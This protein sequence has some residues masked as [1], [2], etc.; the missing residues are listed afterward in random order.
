M[1]GILF[2]GKK[3]RYCIKKVIF[4]KELAEMVFIKREGSNCLN[5]ITDLENLNSAY[6]ILDY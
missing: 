4:I 1:Q 5:K 3:L 2:N 6:N